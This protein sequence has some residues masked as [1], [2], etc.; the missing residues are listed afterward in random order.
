MLRGDPL[1][2]MVL[3]ASIAVVGIAGVVGVFITVHP[4]FNPVAQKPLPRGWV[5]ESVYVSQNFTIH[6][7]ETFKDIFAYAGAGGQSM[8]VLAVQ[9]LEI[10]KPGDIVIVFN[11]IKLGRTSVTTTQVTSI[12]IASCCFVQLVQAGVDNV[13]EITSIDFEGKMRYLVILP[14]VS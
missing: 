5:N 10:K 12:S 4:Y 8:M 11:G 13:V 1:K 2:L 7:G 9:P 6:P 3:I 14:T